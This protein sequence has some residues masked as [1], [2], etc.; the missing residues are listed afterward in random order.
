MDRSF[1]QHPSF[2]KTQK[3][4]SADQTE[5]WEKNNNRVVDPVMYKK[6]KT[7]SV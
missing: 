4:I 5:R 3:S 1:L 6:I 7:S 2:H